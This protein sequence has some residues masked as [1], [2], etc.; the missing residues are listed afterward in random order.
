MS[1][2]TESKIVT[3]VTQKD[4]DAGKKAL[5]SKSRDDV[6]KE[7]ESKFADDQYVI[8]DSFKTTV[9]K[10]ESAPAVGQEASEPNLSLSVTYT[11]LAVKR[12]DIS[13]LFKREA[14]KG[15]SDK[16]TLGVVADGLDNAQIKIKGKP[17]AGGQD[18]NVKGTATLGPSL[19]LEAIKAT[20]AGKKQGDAVQILKDY[21]NVNSV[22]VHL[23]PF[24]V[25]SL[26]KNPKKIDIKIEV[27]AAN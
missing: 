25:R 16:S 15:A 8:E 23:S 10:T 27:P 17:L 14:V 2:G 9:T 1:G 4:I 26:P 22:E 13:E 12:A 24:W 20:L 5:L 18:F 21:P 3:V 6:I 19:D 11:V 7:L